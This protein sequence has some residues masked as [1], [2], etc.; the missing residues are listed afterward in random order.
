MNGMP[1]II[2][3]IHSPTRECREI[4]IVCAHVSN[5]R[6]MTHDALPEFRIQL[7]VSCERSERRMRRLKGVDH[8]MERLLGKPKREGPGVCADINRRTVDRQRVPTA[9]GDVPL[10]SAEEVYGQIDALSKIQF[11]IDPRAVDGSPRIC[12]AD[13]DDPIKHPGREKPNASARPM[14]RA[15]V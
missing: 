8:P 7:N 14:E 6:L 9:I 12:P 1:R 15:K 2:D 5:E 13:H 4:R 11:V 10:E 3:A